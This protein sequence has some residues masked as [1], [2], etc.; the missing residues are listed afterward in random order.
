M[1]YEIPR[2][3]K[4][5]SMDDVPG[6]HRKDHTKVIAVGVLRYSNPASDKKQSL[7]RALTAFFGSAREIALLLVRRRKN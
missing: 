1:K 2:R 5:T 7:L 3:A 6:N 4:Y